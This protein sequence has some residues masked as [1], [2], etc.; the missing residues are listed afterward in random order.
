MAVVGVS[1]ATAEIHCEQQSNHS[2][3][4]RLCDLSFTEAIHVKPHQKGKWNCEGDSECSPRGFSQSVDYNQTETRKRN[5][6]DEQNR[7][8]GNEPRQWTNFGAR[9]FSKLLAFATHT[10]RQDHE[11]VNSTAETNTDYQ[12]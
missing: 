3:N 12:P 6:H 1:D 5:Y 11:V 10:P 7:D 8:A 2:D 9:H 4:A